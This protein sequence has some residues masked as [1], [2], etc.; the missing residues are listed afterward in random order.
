MPRAEAEHTDARERTA[1]RD[2]PR[3]HHV[4]AGSDALRE[5]G[6]GTVLRRARLEPRSL[7]VEG[8]ERELRRRIE[9]ETGHRREP[10]RRPDREGALLLEGRAIAR[11]PEELEGQPEPEPREVAREVGAV[12]RGVVELPLVRGE[13]PGGGGVQRA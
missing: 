4:T 1:L 8:Q 3:E 9:H 10:L 13:I 11:Q 5:R 6:R 12:L 7:E 2:A